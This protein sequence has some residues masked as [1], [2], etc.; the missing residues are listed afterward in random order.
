M[1]DIHTLVSPLLILVL[2]TCLSCA[3]FSREEQRESRQLIEVWVPRDPNQMFPPPDLASPTGFAVTPSE[4][5]SIMM[6]SG[7]LSHKH[8]WACYRDD[9]HYYIYDMFL[10]GASAKTAKKY[11]FK[12]NGQTGE[13]G[14]PH[15]R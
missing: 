15:E 10:K 2:T 6:D 7:R 8:F 14:L 12:V 13:I 5:Y 11:G 4:A 1:R 9:T 3:T